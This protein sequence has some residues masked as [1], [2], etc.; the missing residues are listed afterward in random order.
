MKKVMF[1]GGS[2]QQIAAIQYAKDQGY[3][4]VLCDYLRDNP[5][6]FYSDE[7][8]CVSTTDKEAILEVATQMNINGIVAYS[9]E[10]AAAT[11]AYVGNK[12][13]LPSNPYESVLIL[14]NKNLFRDFLMKHGFNCP[15]AKSYKLK[16]E[17]REN[18]SEFQ[19]PIMVKPVDSSGS[20]G[21]TRV[22]S[23]EEFDSAFDYSLSMSKQKM[24]IIEEYVEMAHE[25]MIGGDLIVV[26]GNIEYFGFL[27]GYRDIENNSFVPTGNSYPVFM[28]E[29]KL[30]IVRNELQKVIELLKIKMGVLNIEVLFD[31]NGK[32][33]IVEIAARNGGNMI[34][35]LLEMGTGVDLVRTTVEA[36]LNNNEIKITDTLTKQYYSTYYLH[37]FEKGKLKDIIF[38]EEIQGNIIHKVINKKY[39][40]GLDVFEGL[41]KTIGIIF[42][43]FNSSEELKSKMKNIKQYI[44]IQ[45]IDDSVENIIISK[46]QF[47]ESFYLFDLEK[48]REN[49]LNMFSAFSSK[50]KKVIIGYSYK[51]NY[52]PTLLKEVSNLGAYAEVVSRM[53]YDLA[54]KIGVDP[55]KIIFNGPLKSYDDIS[56]ALEEG[57]II[58]LDS[59][60]EIEILKEYILKNN[61]QHYKVGLR[62]N[63]DLTIDGMSP[64]QGGFNQSR[65]GFCVENGNLERALNELNK[66]GNIDVVGLHGHFSTQIRSLKVFEKITQKLCDLS[67]KYIANTLEYLDIGGGFYGDVPKIMKINNVPS[68]DDY[69][70]TISSIINKEKDNF[71]NEPY[72]IIE[73]GLSLVVDTFKFYSQV[74]DVKKNR[75]EYFVLVN[76]SVHNIKPSISKKN[77]PMDLVK[78]NFD[79]YKIER[80]NVVGYTCMEKDYLLI[81]HVGEIPKVG[82]FLIF[83]NVGAYTIVL[84]PPFIKERPPI[85]AKV[86]SEFKLVRKREK[87]DDFINS[88][89]YIF[90]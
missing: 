64:L 29:E 4:T 10:P 74:I 53:E 34:S 18:L 55:R 13:N 47:G 85:I 56:M 28:E 22:V 75:D 62:V 65:F 23:L 57:S 54:L 40:D 52:L 46:K 19:F 58:N 6:Q 61:S 12:L 7:Y 38:K 84:N 41:N 77:T 27:N 72:L 21:V 82:D 44:D 87:L 66:I 51:T 33:F 83:S 25:C 30:K 2:T 76:G 20:R 70:K 1:L 31:K 81:D 71:K 15:K 78:T 45:M 49:Y 73:P 16:E 60:Y 35:Q 36:A 59:F 9:S 24:V 80:F 17:A 43:K 86:G 5:G 69:A 63:F 79:D 39:G 48:L 88:N 68:F 50:Y 26:N 37:T 8:H 89:I 11:A 3:Y 90:N 32:P 14:S 42:L 67:K